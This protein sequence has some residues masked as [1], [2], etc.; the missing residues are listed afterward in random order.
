M[1]FDLFFVDFNGLTYLVL[2]F[3][4]TWFAYKIIHLVYKM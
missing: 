4:V 3:G 1:D 2:V